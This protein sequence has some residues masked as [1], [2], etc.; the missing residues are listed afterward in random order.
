MIIST[1]TVSFSFKKHSPKTNSAHDR[2]DKVLGIEIYNMYDYL[3]M[4]HHWN[5]SGLLLHEYCHLIHQHV[6]GLDSIRIQALYQQAQQSQLY[7]TVLRRDWAGIGGGAANGTDTDLAYCMMDCKEFFAELSVT[8]LAQHS[9]F[10]HLDTACSTNMEECSPPITEPTVLQRLHNSKFNKNNDKESLN[11]NEPNR[12][13]IL[14]W[15]ETVKKY[16]RFSNNDSIPHCNKFY[17]FTSGQFRHYDPSLCM[18][19]QALWCDVAAWEDPHDNTDSGRENIVCVN[20]Q[21]F[22]NI[23]KQ[24]HR[25]DEHKVIVDVEKDIGS[26]LIP[27]AIN[28][29]VDL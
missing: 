20:C 1:T 26:P 8:Y 22:H 29:T 12:P 11:I 7:D 18:E 16:L 3:R 24:Q 21:W 25:N 28:D 14:Q 9:M 5:G 17:P 15:I 19:I 2:P 13:N 23:W 10:S 6:F 27:A 4:R